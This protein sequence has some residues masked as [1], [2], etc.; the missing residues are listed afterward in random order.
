VVDGTAAR[1]LVLV[2]D[3]EGDIV[4]LVT[5][6]LE[7]GGYAV[8]SAADG[9]RALE[10]AHERVPVLCILD[11]TMPGLAGFEI[12]HAIRSEPATAAIRVLIL[13]ATVDEEREIRRHGV[14]PDAFMNKP[15]EVDELL[16]EVTR[17]VR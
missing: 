4:E 11:G 17:L 15:F 9:R 13:T 10:L 16:G 7:R 5:I 3:D 8:I 14:E 6:V 2:A 1:P 12:L